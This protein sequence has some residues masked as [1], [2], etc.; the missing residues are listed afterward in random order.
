MA[1]LITLKYLKDFLGVN[2]YL[3]LVNVSNLNPLNIAF[4]ARIYNFRIIKSNLIKP[5]PNLFLL[6]YK[7]ERR[8]NIAAAE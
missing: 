1:L 5:L 6:N 8:P 2:F 4:S 3:I 7:I